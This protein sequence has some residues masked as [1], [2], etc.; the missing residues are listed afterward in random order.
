MICPHCFKKVDD[1]ATI[2]PFCHGY[3]ATG[4]VTHPEFVFCEGCGARLSP[5]DRTCPK[6]GRPAPGILS[7][8]AAATDLAAGNT[9]SFP[10]VTN[11]QLKLPD[12]PH[13][14][15]AEVLDASFDSDATSVISVPLD[16]GPARSAKV[17]EDPYHRPRRPWRLIAAVIVVL[18][19]VGGGA[20]F[21]AADPL[22]VMP[23]V[24]SSIKQS[25]ADMF[26]SRPGMGGTSGQDA[27]DDAEKEGGAAEDA[28]SDA[29]DDEP[30]PIQETSVLSDEDA[31]EKILAAYRA[32]GDYQT[33]LGEIITTYNGSYLLSSRSAR[34]E[35]AQGAYDLRDEVQATIDELDAMQ[36][37]RD[38]V[39]AEDLA[40][41]QSLAMWMYNRV[42]VLCASWDVSLSF[43]DGESMASHEAEILQPLRDALDATGQNENLVLFEQNYSAWYPVQK[44]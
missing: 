26:P 42:D 5:H 39:Y 9:A 15:A 4:D 40:H 44:S 11:A 19:L 18:A 36:L 3:L 14:L 23:G 41:M 35:A 20:Y 37:T 6:C 2:C 7:I 38:S 24:F 30:Q 1:A 10:K 8:D 16:E 17:G 28:N 12:A 21:V 27:S 43:A 25:A 29:A 13:P 33:P 22:G 31:Y 34:E 32:I